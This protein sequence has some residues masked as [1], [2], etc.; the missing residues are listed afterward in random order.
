MGDP[1]G[2]GPEVLLKAISRRHFRSSLI[3]IGDLARLKSIARRFRLSVP[4][5]SCRWIDCA[6]VPKKLPFGAPHPASG[7][8]AY[9]YLREAVSLIKQDGADGL[10]TAPVSKEAVVSAGVRNWIGHTEF[11][12]ESFGRRTVMMF[13]SGKFRV[14][15]VTTHVSIRRLPHQL[16]AAKV[17][18]VIRATR[19]ALQRDFGIRRPRIGLC[20]LNPHG[21]EGGMFGEEESRILRPAA[22]SFSGVAGPLPA[23]S[24]VRQAADG[25][26]DA[27][28]AIYHDQA[29][30]PLKLLGWS[31]AV[32]VTLG[33]PFVRTS[34]VHGTA[35]D[36]AAS[37][38][39]DCGSMESAIRLAED[40]TLRRGKRT[41]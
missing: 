40:L 10:V 17:R 12:G 25:K 21:G 27:L 23:D 22:R 30:I 3:V 33:L 26:F 18:G 7:R 20:A 5:S 6:N 39:A 35:F 1:S 36:I 37:G 4:W 32:N 2:V 9:A 38:K 16:T 41:R 14:S 8:A 34:P 11:L 28:V 19:E 31:R 15:L 24:A 13:A 29:L